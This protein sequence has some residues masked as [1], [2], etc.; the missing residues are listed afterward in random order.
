MFDINQFNSTKFKRRTE[1]VTVKGLQQFFP[2][3]EKAEFI[4]QGLKHSEVAQCAEG[5]QSKDNLKALLQ[6]A[7]GHAPSIKE[8]VGEIIGGNDK[9]PKDTQKRILHLVIGAVEPKIDEAMAVK[10]SET[11]PVEFIELTTKIL[12]LTGLGQVAIKKQ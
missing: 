6:A 7:A 8:A 2:E 11:F 4:V 5:L 10:L 12:E 9:V 1:V 3:G